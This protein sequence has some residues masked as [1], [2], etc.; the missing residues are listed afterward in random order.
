MYNKYVVEISD[1]II[2]IMKNEKL[3]K[4][5]EDIG[6]N[7]N[8]ANVYLSTLSLGSTTVLK[9]SKVSCIKRSTVYDIVNSLKEKGL[10]RI[11]LKGLKQSYVC[12][13]PERLEAVLE[14]RKRD[15]SARLPE[16]MAMYKLQGGESSIKYYSGLKAMKQIYLDSLNEVKHGEEYLVITNEEKWFNLDPNFWLKEYIE[17][18]AKFSYKTRI[19][20]QDSETARHQKKFQKNFNQEFKIFKQ[21]I[22]LD[23]DM[24]L[25]PNKLIIVDL[26]T[27]LTTLVIENKSIIELQKHMF[28]IIWNSVEN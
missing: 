12:E 25:L 14:S 1:R 24:L 7:P 4:L 3:T 22:N 17:E 28:E 19:L 11:D 10:M 2:K 13:N 5:L 23:I 18:R 6:L 8:E 21:K 27:P 20:S 9:I 26:M 15:F 16:L